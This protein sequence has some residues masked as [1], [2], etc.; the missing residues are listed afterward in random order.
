VPLVFVAAGSPEALRRFPTLASPG[1]AEQLIAVD[2][3]GAVY[4]ND[5][6]WVMC[7]FAL[8]ETR[9]WSIRLARPLLRPLARQ[10]FAAV[11]RSRRPVSCWLGLDDRTAAEQLRQVQ[12]PACEV[13]PAASALRSIHEMISGTRTPGLDGLGASRPSDA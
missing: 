3:E 6:A 9:E 12:A 13:A 5:A 8:V 1:G 4:R 2:D 11:S 7:L 10:A